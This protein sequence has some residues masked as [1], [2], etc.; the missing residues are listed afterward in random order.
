MYYQY[1]FVSM[2][3]NVGQTI[4]AFHDVSLFM[5]FMHKLKNEFIRGKPF[6]QED[7]KQNI[8]KMM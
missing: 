4:E 2:A 7:I 1:H 6:E 5:I 3:E 8:M